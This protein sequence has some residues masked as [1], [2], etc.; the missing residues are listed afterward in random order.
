VPLAA[1]LSLP[2]AAPSAQS[3][4]GQTVFRAGTVL[5]PVDVRVLDRGGKAVADLKAE[6]FVIRENGVPQ[7]L[8]HFSVQSLSAST[9]EA[10]APLRRTGI[11][12][13]ALSPQ[14]RRLFLIVLGRGRL[15]EPS[16]ALDALLRFVRD[17][18]LPQDQ[19]A[20]MAW[21]RAT[22]FTT[23]HEKV[24]SVIGRFRAR[25]EEIEMDLRLQLGGL[26]G[27]YAGR[28]LPR[29]IQAKIDDV[30]NGP[31]VPAARQVLPGA[32][33][34]PAEAAARRNADLLLRKSEIELAAEAVRGLGGSDAR[35]MDLMAD[36]TFGMDFDDYVALS[37]QTLQDVGNL[38]AGIDYLRFIEGEKHLIF[39]TEQGFLLPTADYDRD[40]A[41][42][43]AAARVAIDTIQTGGVATRMINGFPEVP[44]Q[45][46]FA[47]GALRTVSEM[48]GG[49]VS[50]SRYGEA[51][52]DRILQATTSGYLLGYT[53]ADSAIDG[54]FRKITVEVK[55]RGVS[56]SHRRG[57]FARAGETDFDPR[58]SLATTRMVSA[59][60]FPAEVKDLKLSIKVSDVR[61]G[62]RR[63]VDVE[64]TVAADRIVFASLGDRHL[65][66]L[67]VA[68]LC[69]DQQGASV[70]E[71]W[72]P[73]DM[74]V[75]SSLLEAVKQTGLTF[76]VQVP[77]R[78]PP[79][80]VKVI[81][82]DYGA[83]LIGS[84]LTRAR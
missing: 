82:Y 61:N 83:D 74:T 15:Q 16:K 56:V 77:V 29:A 23:E 18:L 24:A 66:A 37:R 13:S 45:T 14:N 38:Y 41:A 64:A 70:G 46:S 17:R 35:L 65:A 11:A 6:D 51:A 78:S 31:W 42:Q 62:S 30:F 34:D 40:V 21:N 1:V 52:F 72:R 68:V 44:P 33:T 25:H 79:I 27:L 48:S 7:E 22:D 84:K 60:N 75:S 81:V 54:S 55:R 26:A 3:P 47:L 59:A 43:A 63:A 73:V 57:Y 32:A 20:L 12:P 58:R 28:E 67:N 69:T 2:L 39:L 10:G 9:A 36:T 80:F 5:V 71:L 8:R 4:Q 53:P 49:Q 50:I 76:S 19:I